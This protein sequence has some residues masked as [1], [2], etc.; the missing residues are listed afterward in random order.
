[1]AHIASTVTLEDVPIPH[2]GRVAIGGAKRQ[3]RQ[4]DSLLVVRVDFPPPIMPGKWAY[5]WV[6]VDGVD[7]SLFMATA[8]GSGYAWKALGV[9]AG[10]RAVRLLP[11][12]E[13]GLIEPVTLE[14]RRGTVVLV[15]L[16]ADGLPKFR[17]FG[18]SPAPAS[19]R[20]LPSGFAHNGRWG[21]RWA[22]RLGWVGP[23]GQPLEASP[24]VAGPST[25]APRA[26]ERIAPAVTAEDAPV[27][28]WVETAVR[29]A[30]RRP[31]GE[32]FALP[33][34]RP[35]CLL[36]ARLSYPRPWAA[37]DLCGAVGGTIQVDSVDSLIVDAVLF[38]S[39]AVTG[40]RAGRHTISLVDPA[41]YLDVIEPVTLDLA[42]GSVV[43]LELR[44]ANH[45]GLR[46]LGHPLPSV[47]VRILPPAS[48]EVFFRRLGELA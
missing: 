5:V 32:P 13:D 20:V 29:R 26:R 43:L 3:L 39:S 18:A 31:P 36:A 30:R 45:R 25:P 27:P 28:G 44:P 22:R 35:E 34:G 6:G 46:W 10:R 11:N 12:S 33:A 9:P 38:M 40:I 19:V 24:V 41:S 23:D 2:W 42:A 1:M 4:P 16:Q 37:R 17:W 47:Q 8:P 7:D 48:C 15:E 21:Q 14:F